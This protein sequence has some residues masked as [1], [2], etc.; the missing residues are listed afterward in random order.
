M[1]VAAKQDGGG[2]LRTHLGG[3]KVGALKKAVNTS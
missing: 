1:N 3:G 2:G